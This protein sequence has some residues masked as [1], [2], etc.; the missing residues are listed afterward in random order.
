MDVDG[1]VE[2]KR[3]LANNQ[4]AQGTLISIAPR[5]YVVKVI[6]PHSITTNKYRLRLIISNL[7]PIINYTHNYKT[8]PEPL[9]SLDTHFQILEADNGKTLYSHILMT[10]GIEGYTPQTTW[11]QME[12]QDNT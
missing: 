6:S 1:S 8:A 11:I 2:S 4:N 3:R 5:R 7:K 10:L 12:N 9:N